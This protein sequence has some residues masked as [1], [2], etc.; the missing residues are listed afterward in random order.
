MKK[1]NL[2]ICDIC[3]KVIATKKCSLCGKDLC[4][5]CTNGRTI[6]TVSLDFCKIC[7]RKIK[8]INYDRP[9]FWEEFNIAENMVEKIVQH[10]KKS[11]MLKNLGN[12]DDDDDDDYDDDDD[13]RYGRHDE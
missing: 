9:S 8:R 5:G 2:I 7:V 12:E 13:F 6:G 4:D 3:G 11:L 10:I 1:T